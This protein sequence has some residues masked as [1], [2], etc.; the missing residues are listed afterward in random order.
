VSAIVPALLPFLHGAL[1]AELGAFE[2]HPSVLIGCLA[3]GAAYAWAVGPLARR[4]GWREVGPER[5][6]TAAWALALGLVFL[7]LNGPLH[8]LSDRYLFSAHMAQHMVLMLIVP[9]LLIVGVPPALVRRAVRHPRA[10]EVGRVLTHPAVAFVAYNAV[11]VGWHFPGA[12]N[13]A[14]EHHDL[15]IVQHLM[16]MA[17][18]T[19][20][21]WPVIAPAPELERL[22]DGPLLMIYVFAL[23]IPSTIVSAFITM[24]DTVLY[25]FYAAAPRVSVLSPLEDQRLGGLLM[26]IPGMLIFWLAISAVWFRWTRDE[27]AEWRRE[28]REAAAART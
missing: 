15:H 1:G 2:L 17:T 21:W 14:L 6:R 16:F 18:A 27:Y 12:Y 23:G 5:G 25:P 28:A 9:P 20:M 24:S 22:P 13:A 26:W 11:F 3:L 19:M 8:E 10:L 7:S 4:R